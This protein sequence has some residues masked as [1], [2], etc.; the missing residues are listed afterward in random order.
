[1]QKKFVVTLVLLA[2]ASCTPQS[3][4]S[5]PNSTSASTVSSKLSGSGSRGAGAIAGSASKIALGSYASTPV[6]VFGYWGDA[7]EGSGK[8]NYIDQTQN[9]SNVHHISASFDG[10]TSEEWRTK[11]LQA[12]NNGR[13]KVILMVEGGIFVWMSAKLAPG[14]FENMRKLDARLAGLKHHIMGVYLID[15]PFWKNSDLAK[16]NKIPEADVYKNVKEAAELV[17][18]YFP[19][20]KV[21]LTEAA[22]AVLARNIKFPASVD[23][24]G[25]NCYLYYD[26]CKTVEE[27]DDLYRKT[28]QNLLPNQKMIF[29]LDAHWKIK[30]VGMQKDTQIELI[31][32]NDEIIALSTHYPTAAYFAFL[33]QSQDLASGAEDMPL[34]KDYFTQMGTN[35]LNGTFKP[36]QICIV[37][38]PACEG[39]DYVHRNTCGKEIGRWANA[40]EPYCPKA[41]APIPATT[42][43]PVPVAAPA[44]V[45]AGCKVLEPS[46][47]GK[48]WV[49]RDTCG[50]ELGRWLN[51]PTPYCQTSNCKVLEPKCEVNDWVR[52]DTC[53]KELGRWLN[54][55]KD[56]CPKS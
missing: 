43:A 50:K 44:P 32:R 4:S 33:Y 30:S 48:D 11:I 35:I 40:P 5:K 16:E 45:A 37:M 28:A 6:P 8:G 25:M 55:P 36:N 38:D 13:N 14:R 2:L 20:A 17:K 51:A 39:K 9:V 10:E 54:A 21:I 31:K 53:G 12:T 23:W 47:E 1:M 46:C 41:G 49:R 24:I 26:E 52:R 34:I 27:L 3:K 22:P 15:E 7:M 56:Y 42:P 18:F 19:S 29:T